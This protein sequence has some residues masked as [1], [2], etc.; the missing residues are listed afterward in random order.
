[1]EPRIMGSLH[2]LFAFIL[3]A[4]IIAEARKNTAKSRL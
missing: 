3:Y 1:M 2:P 4:A